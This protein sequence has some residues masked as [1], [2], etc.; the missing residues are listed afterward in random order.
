MAHYGRVSALQPGQLRRHDCVIRI[1]DTLN[2]ILFEGTLLMLLVAGP[3]C[4]KSDRGLLT[5][6]SLSEMTHSAYLSELG[7]LRVPGRDAQDTV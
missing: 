3:R 6:H 7:T 4:L 2:T 5:A 1:Q